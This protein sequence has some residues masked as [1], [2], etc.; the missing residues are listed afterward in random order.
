[1][2][3]T[4]IGTGRMSRS[5]SMRLLE[6]GHNITLLEHTPG[7]AQALAEELKDQPSG[8]SIAPAKPGTLP[9]EVVIL[10]VP[11][12]AAESTLQE[13]KHLLADKT[14]VDITNPV[15]YQTME[16]LLPG[17]SGAEQIAMLVPS[18][19]PVVKAFNTVFAAT[20][21]T[22]R[23]G[24]MPLDIFIAGDNPDSKAKVVQLIESAGMRAIDAGPLVRARQLEALG[25]LHMIIQPATKTGGKSAIKILA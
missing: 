16:P 22:G 11:Y 17:S 23:V 25:L 1:M 4:I 9:G 19:T 14:L 24:N 2:N 20:L 15:N 18:G 13:Y 6:G 21:Q 10:A 12:R 3:V 7:R 5:L 8:G